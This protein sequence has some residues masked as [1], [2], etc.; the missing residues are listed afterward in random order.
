[1]SEQESTCYEVSLNRFFCIM[2]KNTIIYAISLLVFSLISVAFYCFS[3]QVSV[4]TPIIVSVL[5][6]LIL[7]AQL[8]SHPKYMDVTPDTVKFQ[9]RK[10]L[11][12]L[13]TTG[14]ISSLW[15]YTEEYTIYHITKIDYVQSAF[16]K[17]FH[18]GRVRLTGTVNVS[19][20]GRPLVEERTFTLYRVKDFENT[21]A[22][23]KEY[24][25]LEDQ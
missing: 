24:V 20:Y 15:S 4:T 25:H 5:C 23:M 2:E 16:E 12:K 10:A 3:D 21:A 18:V 11:L 6:V 1:M 17:A 9:Y 8:L 13:L 14:H 7:I 19:K 22:W